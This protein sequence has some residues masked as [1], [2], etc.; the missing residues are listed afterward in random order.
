M[1]FLGPASPDKQ[2]RD[3]RV[4]YLRIIPT[5][6]ELYLY[7]I[8]TDDDCMYCKERDSIDHTLRDCHFVTIFTQQVINWFNVVNNTK[9]NPSREERLFGIT[10]DPQDKGIKN[11]FSYSML[12]MR[13]FTYTNLPN[14][15]NFTSGLR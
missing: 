12:F 5:K 3:L 14:K 11:K 6:R 2:Y 13:C 4:Y 1:F 9:F 15:T 10:S 7:G 8:K